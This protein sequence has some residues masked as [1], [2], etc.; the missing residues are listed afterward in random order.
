[1]SFEK[2]AKLLSDGE[3]RAICRACESEIRAMTSFD[4]A[5]NTWFKCLES[6]LCEH[7]LPAFSLSQISRTMVDFEKHNNEQ[8]VLSAWRP[9][10]ARSRT[11]SYQISLMPDLLTRLYK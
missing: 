6:F 7:N 5:P 9:R 1:M 2:Q 4:Q 10:R 11:R 3:L 8:L